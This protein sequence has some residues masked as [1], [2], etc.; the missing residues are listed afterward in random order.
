MSDQKAV[1]RPDGEV[2][3][4]GRSRQISVSKGHLYYHVHCRVVHNS[5]DRNST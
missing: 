2:D 1:I 3:G 5:E 4:E